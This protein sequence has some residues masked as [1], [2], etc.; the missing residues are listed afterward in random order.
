MIISRYSHSILEM[1]CGIFKVFHAIYV[2]FFLIFMYYMFLFLLFSPIY[3]VIHVRS[4]HVTFYNVFRDVQVVQLGCQ[5]V[6]FRL[7]K[8]CPYNILFY[9]PILP[10]FYPFFI[11]CFPFI[12]FMR[13]CCFLYYVPFCHIS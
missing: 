2:M 4:I 1:I 3:L 9:F 5:L 11:F 10:R 8:Q 6:H 7:F 12:N 13:L